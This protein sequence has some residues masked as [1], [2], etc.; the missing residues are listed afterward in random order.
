MIALV[1]L[2]LPCLSLSLLS[3]L[4]WSVSIY[5]VDRSKKTKSERKK[6][7]EGGGERW[8]GG[9]VPRLASRGRGR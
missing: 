8:A 6:T 5:L 4:P 1:T 7:N 3:F 9:E 2:V